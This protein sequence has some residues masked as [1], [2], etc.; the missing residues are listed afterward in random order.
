MKPLIHHVFTI[1]NNRPNK[2]IKTIVGKEKFKSWAKKH[3][4]E[5][6]GEQICFQVEGWNKDFYYK[7]LPFFYLQGKRKG[8][9][10]VI[11]TELVQKEDHDVIF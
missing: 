7:A 5:D 10:R 6:C 4:F 9:H 8:K 1:K 2:K 11:F 3:Y